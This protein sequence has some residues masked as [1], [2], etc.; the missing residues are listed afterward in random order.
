MVEEGENEA[1]ELAGQ[2][3]LLLKGQVS[4]QKLALSLGVQ[5]QQRTKMHAFAKFADFGNARLQGRIE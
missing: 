4:S 5:N 1:G 3:S 2:R